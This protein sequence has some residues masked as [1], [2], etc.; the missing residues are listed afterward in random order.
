VKLKLPPLVL[1]SL[2][3]RLYESL[4]LVPDC[5]AFQPELLPLKLSTPLRM[6]DDE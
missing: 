1:L 3:L 2:P 5:P 4:P 6:D